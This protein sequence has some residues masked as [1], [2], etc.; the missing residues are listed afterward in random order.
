[1]PLDP[2]ARVVLDQLAAMG[3]PAVNE[4]SP[5]QARANMKLRPRAPGPEVA[6]VE[7]RSIPGPDGDVPVRIYIP[8][9][10]GP[11]PDSDMVPRRRL[12]YRRLGV[13]R[14][15][16]A[17]FVRWG[18][19]RGGFRGLPLGTRDKVPRP[20]RRLLRRHLSGQWTTPP[21]STVIRPG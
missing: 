15:P 20:C 6:K 11:I 10:S 13:R 17:A 16:V 2:Q 3:L 7:D 4:V 19:L 1:M 9:G 21:P 18:G 12:G 8:E 5:E 14:R